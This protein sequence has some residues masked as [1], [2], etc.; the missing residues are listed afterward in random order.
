M[1]RANANNDF[2][3][4]EYP[5][6]LASNKAAKL[7]CPDCGAKKHWQRYIDT[8]TGKVL[9][10][11]YGRCDN[12]SKCGAWNDPYDEGYG[13]S[14]GYLGANNHLINRSPH[15]TPVNIS[16]VFIPEDVLTTTLNS[17]S[18]E[19]NQFIQNLLTLVP[20]PFDVKDVERVIS[21]YYLG[22]IT[23][24]HMAGGI[25][26]PYIDRRSN[27]RA[28]QVKK[29]DKNNTTTATSFLHSLAEKRFL[30]SNKPLPGW[31]Q[32]YKEQD[33]KVSCLFGEHLLHRHPSNPVALVEAPK[34]AIYATLYFGFPDQADKL[35]WLAVFNKSSFT[36]D[37]LK[38]L[39]GRT[40]LV[41]PDLSKESNTYTEWYKKAREFE[42]RLPDTRFI[43]SN[44]LEKHAPEDDRPAGKD[45]AD[46]LISL[47][48]REFR[49][50]PPQDNPKPEPRPAIIPAEPTP[51]EKSEKC[52]PTETKNL[53][54]QSWVK[55][56]SA[57][58]SSEIEDLEL[59]FSRYDLPSGPL[60]LDDCTE[61]LDPKKFLNAH[62]ST[63][64]RYN[65][66]R[67]G[68][69]VLARLRLFKNLLTLNSN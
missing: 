48:W 14:R 17:E 65:G 12:E 63:L 47:D 51:C 28:V 3:M 50:Q 13:K 49:K 22:T 8:R 27:I 38:A 15:K 19:Q 11:E 36:F 37:R 60:R 6:T 30:K 34:T 58:W 42:E 31:L 57:D 16:P 35:L 7:Q 26:F 68:E 10:V 32:K 2:N 56:T 24:G 40:V 43:F 4:R 18:Y 20:Y 25:T 23:L 44:L 29:F 53:F 41:F 21:Q 59:F 33:L 45:L 62:M 64:K 55:E 54:E 9:P 52:E 69:P 1:P 67:I 39:Q 5:Y 66:K 61:I 46:Y